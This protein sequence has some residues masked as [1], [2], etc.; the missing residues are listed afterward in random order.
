[1]TLQRICS[2]L[3]SITDGRV[4]AINT[5]GH[6]DR[7]V[8][9]VALEVPPGD[10]LHITTSSATSVAIACHKCVLTLPRLDPCSVG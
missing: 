8:D 7:L 5:L 9:V 2:Y 10:I 4:A 1:M 3:G 6:I